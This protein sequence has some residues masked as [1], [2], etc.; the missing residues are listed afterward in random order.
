MTEILRLFWYGQIIRRE[1]TYRY[2]Y[3]KDDENESGWMSDEKR[4]VEEGMDEL[5]EEDIDKN[6]TNNRYEYK[7]IL[8]RSYIIGIR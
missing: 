5:C 6:V 7:N 1:E 3:E 2:Y 8:H 4:A